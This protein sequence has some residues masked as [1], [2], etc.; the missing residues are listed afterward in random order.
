MIF[1]KVLAVIGGITIRNKVLL[2]EDGIMGMEVLT[3]MEDTAVMGGMVCI[4]VA[5]SRL[6]TS[7]S[8]FWR[9]WQTGPRMA[10]NSLSRWRTTLTASTFPAPA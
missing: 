1:P 2:T 4:R 8:S 3:D 5:N 10:T 9:S 6:R 7:N